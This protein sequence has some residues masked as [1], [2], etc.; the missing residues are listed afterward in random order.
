MLAGELGELQGEFR[1]MREE[2]MGVL[3]ELN[4]KVSAGRGPENNI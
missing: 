2:V 3:R 4:A 1:A